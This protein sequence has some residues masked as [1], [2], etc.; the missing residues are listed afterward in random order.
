MLQHCSLLKHKILIGL[1]YGLGI[2]NKVRE[3]GKP[4]KFRKCPCC[5]VGNLL[6]IEV[7]GKRGPPAWYVGVSQPS[8]PR[9]D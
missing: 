7:F 3:P 1:L 4:L 6:T 9:E 8:I 5:K 2:K